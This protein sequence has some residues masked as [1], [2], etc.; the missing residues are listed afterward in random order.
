MT[1]TQDTAETTCSEI[2]NDERMILM[3]MLGEVNAR[4]QRIVGAELEAEV[5]IS[6]AWLEVLIRLRRS[7]EDRLT[8][9][10]VADQTVYTSG[11]VT[12]L[13]DR[14]EEAGF[15][16]RINCPTDRRATYVALTDTG[17]E[18]LAEATACYL[19]LIDRHV[20]S[21]LSPEERASLIAALTKLNGGATD[22]PS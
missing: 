21:Q 19:E 8:M 15:V 11:G 10:A 2:V 7:G 12:R 4:L 22:C 1:A 18:K 5:G 14:I 13:V 9:S 3:G 17:A 20:S 6:M 16:Q